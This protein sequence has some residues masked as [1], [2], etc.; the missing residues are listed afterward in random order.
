V[1]PWLATAGS[2]DCVRSLEAALRTREEGPGSSDH[3][4]KRWL[5]SHEPPTLTISLRVTIQVSAMAK[6]ILSVVN[7]I[8]GAIAIDLAFVIEGQADA[9][10]PE[11]LLGGVRLH[12]INLK[13]ERLLR[14]PPVEGD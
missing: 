14:A 8:A 1:R 3:R 13:E 6:Y 11:R 9:E 4:R 7:P 10:L 5:F 12:R 2:S